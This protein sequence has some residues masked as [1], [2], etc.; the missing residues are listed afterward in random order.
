MTHS[1]NILAPQLH[2]TAD[3]AI[4]WFEKN[5]GLSKS[6]ISV[7]TAIHPDIQLRPTFSAQTREF[8]LLCIEVAETIYSN[9]LDS[10]VL[11]CREKGLPV[12]LYVAV[13]KELQDLEYQ[14]KLRR[15]KGRGVGILEVDSNS[16]LVVQNAL[17]SSLAS[18]RPIELSDFPKKYRESLQQ[19]EQSF[20]D[21]QPA[22]ACSQVYDELENAFRKFAHKCS[23]KKLW[24]KPPK[25]RIDKV[26]WASLIKNVDQNLDRKSPLVKKMTG[27]LLGRIH[28]VTSHRNETGHKPKSQTALMKRDKELR[29]RFESAVDLFY[30]FL[31]A[32]K[33]LSL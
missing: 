29:T 10:F 2:I 3:A 9:T 25:M 7:E 33:S 6:R 32:A 14:K 31:A 18:V 30:D 15:A 28:G 17:S 21:G 4:A 24:P 8:H 22:K 23:S 12:K 5:W 26:Q 11:D 13:P 27:A 16:G 19:A 20:R 1:Y